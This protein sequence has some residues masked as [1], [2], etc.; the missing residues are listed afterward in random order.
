PSD[1]GIA[2]TKS[3]LR[4]GNHAPVSIYRFLEKRQ[5]VG[6][7]LVVAGDALERG[8]NNGCARGADPIARPSGGRDAIA[9]GHRGRIRRG[10]L[11]RNRSYQLVGSAAEHAD[12]SPA[13]NDTG[14]AGALAQSVVE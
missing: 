11:L 3:R 5:P 9:L 12:G 6:S 8:K 10:A 14:L 4:G 7:S 13:G 2:S 1:N